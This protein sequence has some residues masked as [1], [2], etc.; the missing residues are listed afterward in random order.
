MYNP[1]SSDIATSLFTQQFN[2]GLSVKNSNSLILSVSLSV[3]T[4]FTATYPNTVILVVYNP[5]NMPI[6]H[7]AS[8]G[9]SGLTTGTIN[10]NSTGIFIIDS[11]ASVGDTWK[12]V[13]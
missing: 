3:S 7:T 12:R 6:I 4:N 11:S 2:N 5:T 13:I 10:A 8:I 1:P 9:F